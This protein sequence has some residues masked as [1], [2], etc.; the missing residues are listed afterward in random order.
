MNSTNAF[1][2]ALRKIYSKLSEKNYIELKDLKIK[3][4]LTWSQLFNYLCDT[5]ARPEEIQTDCREEKSK[6]T[7]ILSIRISNDAWIKFS[8]FSVVFKKNNHAI[9][10]LV[11]EE[12]N[13]VGF[14]PPV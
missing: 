10:Y 3:T 11:R 8:T 12:K 14:L 13:K 7:K 6:K 4:H 5:I 2:M 1:Y 9:D